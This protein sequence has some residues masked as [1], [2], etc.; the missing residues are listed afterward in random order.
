MRLTLTITIVLALICA[1]GSLA[2][3]QKEKKRA[4]ESRESTL[5]TTRDPLPK[6]EYAP[7]ASRKTTKGPTYQSEQQYY[8]RKEELEKIRRKNERL[9]DKPQYSDPMYFGHKRPPKKRKASKM[10][11]CKVCGI[12][13]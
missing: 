1:T 5:P 8:E 11:Y 12:R 13:H 6:K 2:Q 9:M 3:S 10:K 4:K 7:K